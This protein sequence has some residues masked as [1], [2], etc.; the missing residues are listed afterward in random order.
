MQHSSWKLLFLLL[1]RPKRFVAISEDY[2]RWASTPEGMAAKT[3]RNSGSLPSRQ[4]K[5]IRRAL[6]ISFVCVLAAVCAGWGLGL[7]L[8]TYDFPHASK[9]SELTQYLGIGI[10][11]WA[12]LGRG[13]W[14]IQT[15]EG[16]SPPEQVDAFVFQMLYVF[17]SLSLSLSA[18]LAYGT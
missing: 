15:L 9:A 2:E 12:T 14:H 10:L 11:L 18:S 3:H 1:F 16:V 6:F 13:G 5:T 4:T 7:V 17:G 8:L